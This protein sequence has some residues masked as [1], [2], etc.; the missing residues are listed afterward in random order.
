MLIIAITNI[1][2]INKFQG[3]TGNKYTAFIFTGINCVGFPLLHIVFGY[4]MYSS[5][6]TQCM[7]TMEFKTWQPDKMQS[8]LSEHKWNNLKR[9]EIISLLSGFQTHKSRKHI[10]L[11]FTLLSQAIL[12]TFNYSIFDHKNTEIFLVLNG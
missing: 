11:I 9:Q 10:F 5:G 7:S 1:H 3:S 8:S 12:M 6:W 2:L 4:L